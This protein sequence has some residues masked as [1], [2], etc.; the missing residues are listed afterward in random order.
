MLKRKLKWFKL[1]GNYSELVY[2]GFPDFEIWKDSRYFQHL[3]NPWRFHKNSKMLCR[4]QK[5]SWDSRSFYNFKGFQRILKIQEILSGFNKTS[6]KSWI[7]STTEAIH[8]QIDKLWYSDKSMI[9]SQCTFNALPM[10]FQ[11]IFSALSMHFQCTF[12]AL[13]IHLQ[14][15][16]RA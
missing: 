11:C 3:R 12:G 13:S 9:Y 16:F 14:C 10:H 15:T 8:W 2:T 1:G 7:Y 5:I 6:S 4:S